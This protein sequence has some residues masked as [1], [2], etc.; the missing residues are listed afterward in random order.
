M[1]K[2]EVENVAEEINTISSDYHLSYATHACERYNRFLHEKNIKKEIK[3][4]S[5][6]LEEA[7]QNNDSEKYGDLIEE[8]S[9]LK[10]FPRLSIYIDYVPNM[11]KGRITRHL[12]GKFIINLPESLMQSVMDEKGQYDIKELNRLRKMMAHEVGHLALHF[13]ELYKIHS[14]FG[15]DELKG[16]YETQADCFADK[17]LELRRQRRDKMDRDGVFRQL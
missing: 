2:S 5:E 8:K 9:M 7:L 3:E 6:Q 13:E 12:G 10:A 16:D 15:S 17:L 1:T 4:L 14:N 11:Q